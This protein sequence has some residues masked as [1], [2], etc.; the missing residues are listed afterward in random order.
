MDNLT[1][2]NIFLPQH[3]KIWLIQTKFHVHHKWKKKWSDEILYPKFKVQVTFI[4]YHSVLQNI[5][6][7]IFKTIT[8]GAK[9]KDLSYFTIDQLLNHRQQLKQQFSFYFLH[10][11]SWRK[12][13]QYLSN[14]YPCSFCEHQLSFM[15]LECRTISPNADSLE[16]SSWRSHIERHRLTEMHL[17]GW[18]NII[19][20]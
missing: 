6:L 8:L 2:Q 11:F 18:I 19:N 3:Q 1:L 15:V 4:W 17:S 20:T 9:E 12:C 14:Y 7:A 5:F 13:G 16:M 10:G